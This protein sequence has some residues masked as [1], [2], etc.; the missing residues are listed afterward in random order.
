MRRSF[1]KP[2]D[3]VFDFANHRN[4]WNQI[5]AELGFGQ[6]D[7]KT[8]TYIGLLMHTFRRSAARNLLKMGVRREL[9][10]RITGHLTDEMFDRHGIQTTE[11]V[12]TELRKF[13]PAKVVQLTSPR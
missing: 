4:I 10:E 6:D 2:E 11:D 12:A 1:A 9:A 3:H 13:K 7:K 5:C 8:R